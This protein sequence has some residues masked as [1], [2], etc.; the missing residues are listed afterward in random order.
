M[1]ND[2]QTTYDVG[3]Q[4]YTPRNDGDKYYGQVTVRFAL[5]MSLNNATIRAEKLSLVGFDRVA[6]PGPAAEQV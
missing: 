5:Q 2:E 1:L 6:A 4:E 3:N